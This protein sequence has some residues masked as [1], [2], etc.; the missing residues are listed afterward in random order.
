MATNIV[1]AQENPPADFAKAVRHANSGCVPTGDRIAF[2]ATLHNNNEFSNEYAK[3]VIADAKKDGI[4]LTYVN[5]GNFIHFK[6]RNLWPLGFT[7]ALFLV[8][9]QGAGVV[10]VNYVYKAREIYIDDWLYL[11]PFLNKDV[12]SQ[13][14]M[15]STKIKDSLDVFCHYSEICALMV[16][17]DLVIPDVFYARLSTNFFN[18]STYLMEFRAA[19]SDAGL[20]VKKIPNEM[21]TVSD[22]KRTFT[23]NEKL[24]GKWP[25]P[26]TKSE[27]W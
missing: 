15:T 2:L 24:N 14:I 5:Y 18:D 16:K 11:P 22:G 4:I 7:C 21:F 3:E 17:N 12:K 9:Q 19:F 10:K 13:E 23:F 1:S 25:L 8:P 27:K 6:S 26:Y 20:V